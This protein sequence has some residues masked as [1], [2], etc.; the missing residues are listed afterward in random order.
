MDTNQVIALIVWRGFVGKDV[1]PHQLTD[2]KVL[3]AQ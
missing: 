1:A 3:S 2:H